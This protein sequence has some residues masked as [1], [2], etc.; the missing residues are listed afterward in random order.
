VAAPGLSSSPDLVACIGHGSQAVLTT[1][2]FAVAIVRGSGRDDDRRYS[3]PLQRILDIQPKPQRKDHLAKRPKTTSTQR[4]RHGRA[5]SPLNFA[6]KSRASIN[7]ARRRLTMRPRTAG[8]SA[9]RSL[10]DHT[11]VDIWI[12][13]TILCSRYYYLLALMRHRRPVGVDRYSG[14]MSTF[15]GRPGRALRSTGTAPTCDGG[16]ETVDRRGG[17]PSRHVQ[18]RLARHNP[19]SRR[20]LGPLTNFVEDG[21][22]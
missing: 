5:S 11:A 8:N 2:E 14:T 10:L 12:S 18:V 20:V 22:G 21:G 9:H 1:A 19:R 6:P 4:P 15:R 16:R 13:K 7:S 17:A 3:L